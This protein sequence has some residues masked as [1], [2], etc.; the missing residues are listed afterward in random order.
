MKGQSS[1]MKA[2]GAGAGPLV[3]S[4]GCEWELQLGPALLLAALQL[5]STD[6]KLL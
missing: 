3:T 5:G 2:G 4:P 6:T 1:R